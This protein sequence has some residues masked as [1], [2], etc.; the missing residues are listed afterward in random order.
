LTTFYK[1]VKI[2]QQGEISL[3]A[4]IPN[5]IVEKLDLSKG[6]YMKIYLE[7]GKIVLEKNE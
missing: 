4:T 1:I 3:T 7:N 2:Q 5:D 6:Q